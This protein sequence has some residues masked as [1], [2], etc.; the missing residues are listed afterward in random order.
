MQKRCSG[1]VRGEGKE[2][3]QAQ[4]KSWGARHPLLG[5]IM[6]A[7]AVGFV[8]FSVEKNWER[9]YAEN[10]RPTLANNS[11]AAMREAKKERLKNQIGKIRAKLEFQKMLIRS[12]WEEKMQALRASERKAEDADFTEG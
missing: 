8:A 5:G 1:I 12:G 10:E 4:K 3:P 2:N 6:M 9:R 11:E 7:A